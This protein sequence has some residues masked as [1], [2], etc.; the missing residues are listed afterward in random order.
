M[1]I[2]KIIAVLIFAVLFFGSSSVLAQTPT[3]TPSPSPS[4]T[5]SS[6]SRLEEIQKQINEVE[7]KLNVLEG[8]EKTLSSQ[9]AVIDNQIK[10]T[11]LRIDATKQ[12]ITD[13]TLDIDTADKKINNIENSL[14]DL[15][16]VLVNRIQATYKIGSAP[17]FQVL[18]ASNDVSDFM[19]R[20]NYL[21]IAQAHDRRLIYDTI[22][23]KNDYEHQ[24]DLFQDKKEQ[25]L[26]LNTELESYTAQLGK[27]RGGKQELLTITQNDEAKFQQEL[28]RLKADAASISQALGNVGQKVGPVNKG[29]VIGG[30]GSSGCSTGPHLHFEVFTNAKV[31]NGR[32]IGTRV[33]PKP[34]LENGA[35]EKPVPGYPGN[36]SA[37]YGIQYFL[38]THTGID[39]A[40]PF[41]T[42]IRTMESGEAY[43]TSAACSYSIP[44]GSP[45]GKGIIV[46]HKNGLVTLYWHL[47]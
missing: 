22:Q 9:I 36:V 45:V 46:D 3:P 28:A 30:V 8:Q 4:P 47:P 21:R 12:Q 24:K 37:W 14:D 17:S 15:T 13:L 33:D 31:E 44:G 11:T 16:K 39:M 35:Y 2:K 25:I 5:P 34:Y 19:E 7:S 27:D 40:Q 26:A 1:I 10:L 6:S 38:G 18:L 23:A 43:S 20:A 42:P 29:D 32:V 41:G